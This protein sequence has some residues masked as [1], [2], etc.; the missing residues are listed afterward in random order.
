M[1][2][3]PAS[4]GYCV[5]CGEK[6]AVVT[7]YRPERRFRWFH[8]KMARTRL[9]KACAYSFAVCLTS[10][11]FNVPREAAQRLVKVS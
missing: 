2:A 11:T 6:A 1:I 5:E 9:C 10:V 7:V 3:V 8:R 4:C